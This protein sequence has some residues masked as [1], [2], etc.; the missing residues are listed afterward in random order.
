[1]CADSGLWCNTNAD[2]PGNY[3]TDL[4]VGATSRMMTVKRALRRAI[5]DYADRVSF[6]FMSSYQGRGLN[7]TD[8]NAS[9]AIYPY[10]KLQSCPVTANVTETKLLTRGELERSGCFDTTNG[11]AATC[12]VD[13]GGNGAI[14]PGSPGLN[15]ISYSLVT[16]NDSHWAIPRTDGSGK[17]NHV[18]ASWSSCASSPI[19][20][21]CE[22]TGQGTGLYEGSYYSFSYPQGTPIPNGGVDGEGSR[23]H[24]KYFA[25]YMGKY[26]NAGG[27]NCYNA[28]DAERTDIVNDNVFDRVAYTGTSYSPSNEVGVP[29]G[30]AS[31]AA[32][33]NATTGA[34]WDASVVP[35]LNATTLNG[36]PVTSA[37][38]ALLIAARLEKASFGGIDATGAI[39]PLACVLKNDGAADPYHSAA[40]YMAQAQSTDASNNGGNTPCWSNNIVLVVDGQPNGFGD[41]GNAISCASPAC[42]YD[43]TNN[44]NL[45]GCN[46]AAI[47]KAMS[48]AQA[49]IQTHVVVNAPNYA[50]DT[51]SW[52]TRYPY[53]YAFLWNVAVAGSPSHD[54]TPSFGT[55][56]DEV[57]QA[58]SAKIATAAHHYTYDTASPVAG[59]STQNP[60]TQIVSA[61]SLLFDTTVSYPAFS[62]SLR[63]FDESAGGALLWDAATVA[64]NGTP[65][66]THRLIYFSDQ[67][68]NVVK[69]QIASDGTITN[70]AALY[71]AGL[72]ADA[73]EASLII[74]WLL[75]QQWPIGQQGPLGVSPAVT[76]VPGLGSPYPVMGSISASTPIVVGQGSAN[77]LPGSTQYSQNT[78]TRPQ[79]V[80][81]G[82]DD[83]M[84]HAFFANAGTVTLNGA[85]YSGG[86]E[87]FAFIPN[88]MLPVITKLYAQGG[89][90]LSV[91]SSQHIFGLASSPKVKDMCIGTSCQSSTGGDWHTVLVMP[92]GS[93]GN[94]PFALDITNVVDVANG[95]VPGNMA[96]LWSAAIASSTL[97]PTQWQQSLGQTTSVPAFY[98]AGYVSGAADNRVLFASGY[99]TTARTGAYANQGLTLLNVD[100]SNGAVKDTQVLPSQASCATTRALLAD[101]AVARNYSAS[102][103]PQNLMAAYVADTWGN[104]F[105]YV[106]G[107][108]TP[109]SKLYTLGTS[110]CDQ[111]IYYAP[112]LAQLDRAPS[113]PTSV[114]NLVYLAQV[115]GSALDPV[116][117]PV[118]SSYPGSELVVTELDGNV[119]PPA[120]V[121]NYNQTAGSAQIVL[122]TSPSASPT[123]R[124]CLQAS[125]TTSFTNTLKTQT[126]SCS[127]AGGVPLP[128]SA[129]PMT[130]PTVALR[131]DGLGFQVFATWYD[132]TT[133]S[134]NCSAGGSFSYGQSYLTVHEFGA[135]GTW[136]QVAGLTLNNTVQTGVAFV[137]TSIFGGGIIN[138]ATPQSASINETFSKTQQLI[139]GDAGIGRFLRTMWNE[140]TDL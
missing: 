25:T 31:N 100:V 63:A 71:A 37:Q 98:L 86:E 59:A 135:S 126:Q 133:L 109:L 2:C 67:S 117:A 93:G 101:V 132:P 28:V 125:N 89:Q 34:M 77:G 45:T 55:T 50:N 88:D 3:A 118:S 104:T 99:P 83:G 96:L 62:G 102:S 10:V 139:T 85:T 120:L 127:D 35:F 26:Y 131:S 107:A 24:P 78:W 7:A 17:Y 138:T 111:P 128:E 44:P 41:M 29:W 72:G 40:D 70:A 57:Y 43:A 105:E 66:W 84:L 129:R 58:I 103:T 69:V 108:A 11:P 134:N 61:S 106:P 19:L 75:G 116:T 54:G 4:C 123:N 51:L 81:V 47:T 130:T 32:A 23:A 46:C 27:G 112:A 18:D 74:P 20:P 82:A 6:G 90:R 33:C 73:T 1:M 113:A 94:K 22:L 95:L 39:E 114:K 124:I 5:T 65:G 52:S 48:L 56:E 64:A 80:Y 42:A 121:T 68:G 97:T 87:A 30:G 13:Y 14:N 60:T 137:G 36:A 140:R 122:S 53:T 136:Y 38:K 79:L 9:T 49:G 15:Q 92:E 76:Y 110:G 21:A 16:S 91:S 119:S 8:S 115:T 12:L